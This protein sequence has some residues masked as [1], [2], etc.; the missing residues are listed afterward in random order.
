MLTITTVSIR[1]LERDQLRRGGE[2]I[3][4]GLE[5]TARSLI[6]ECALVLISTEQ[7]HRYV[8]ISVY[9]ILSFQSYQVESAAFF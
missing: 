3:R 9:K 6:G 8:V 5:V 1:N 2:T 7:L 4:R